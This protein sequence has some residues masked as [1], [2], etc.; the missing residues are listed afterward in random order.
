M[1]CSL[2]WDSFGRRLP[3][4][5]LVLVRVAAQIFSASAP[6]PPATKNTRMEH[7]PSH[8]YT[9]AAPPSQSVN[10]S[11]VDAHYNQWQHITRL[12]PDEFHT[13]DYF[14]VMFEKDSIWST[15]VLN[16]F[17]TTTIFDP[18]TRLDMVVTSTQVL[19]QLCRVEAGTD[20]LL[21]LF[22]KQSYYDTY[23]CREEIILSLHL[24]L[25][26]SGLYSPGAPSV[27]LLSR[28]MI[29][30]LLRLV[31]H[32]VH[33]QKADGQERGPTV[34]RDVATTILLHIV[35]GP[36]FHLL[37]FSPNLLVSLVELDDLMPML[38]NRVLERAGTAIIVDL[39][40]EDGDPARWIAT[41]IQL[42]RTHTAVMYR[43]WPRMIMSVY[44]AHG[45]A[46][47][48]TV[49]RTLRRAGAFSKRYTGRLRSQGNLV[50]C[51]ILMD[52]TTDPVRASDGFVYDRD[53][54]LTFFAKGGTR[55]P[56]TRERMSTIVC[57][58]LPGGE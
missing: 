17:T 24:H 2:L 20:D 52:E 8:V 54:I 26:Q 49:T 40:D 14:S 21:L 3:R 15:L 39:V 31:C 53:S 45:E 58:A 11:S 23:Q 6:P 9:A 37:C 44:K 47:S 35:N 55:S 16:P 32:D 41:L 48:L 5:V 25:I 56:L 7:C 51:P 1:C 34:F 42:I 10:A 29:P 38:V 4:R 19:L 18:V 28:N 12:T 33:Q 22:L 46:F 50:E 57:T 27:A 30:L 13:Q 36:D 43:A